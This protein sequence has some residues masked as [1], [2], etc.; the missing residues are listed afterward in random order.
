MVNIMEGIEN[1]PIWANFSEDEDGSIYVELRSSGVAINHIAT[2]HGGGGHLQACGCTVKSF[3]EVY[4]IIN[5]LNDL[6]N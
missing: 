6:L 2:N 4:Q 3:D 5:E 1:I